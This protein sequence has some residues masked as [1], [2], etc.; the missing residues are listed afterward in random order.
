MYEIIPCAGAGRR[1]ARPRFRRRRH[2][3]LCDYICVL[4]VAA[5]I[6]WSQISVVIPLSRTAEA[7]ARVGRHSN[8]CSLSRAR[9]PLT[10]WLRRSPTRPGVTCQSTQRRSMAARCSGLVLCVLLACAAAA[11]AQFNPPQPPSPPLP[12]GGQANGAPS[13]VVTTAPVVAPSPAAV[14]P[15]PSPVFTPSP[16]VSP[17]PAASPSPVVVF[18]PLPSPAPVAVRNCSPSSCSCSLLRFSLEALCKSNGHSH[19]LGHRCVRTC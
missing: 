6:G 3:E 18:T 12:P 11:S 10:R 19:E 8:H 5:T 2:C 15:S 13:P 14:L 9:S 4:A 7:A 16:A 1:D 17:N